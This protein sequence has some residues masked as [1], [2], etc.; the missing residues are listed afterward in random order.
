MQA[1]S[2]PST[3]G[4]PGRERQRPSSR[5]ASSCRQPGRG[6]NA[7]SAG[8]SAGP[9][10]RLRPISTGRAYFASLDRSTASKMANVQARE[11]P[12]RVAAV[13][14]RAGSREGSGLT[15]PLTEPR[16]PSSVSLGA[17]RIPPVSRHAGLD[18]PYYVFES[19]SLA[20][21]GISSGSPN[22]PAGQPFAHREIR[23][24]AS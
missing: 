15:T 7:L 13:R 6:R 18:Q 17:D 16:S 2:L 12:R 23:Y 11:M 9:S 8:N 20:C 10:S 14:R 19:G 24:I 5:S 4:R 3:D 21:S 1:S 22:R